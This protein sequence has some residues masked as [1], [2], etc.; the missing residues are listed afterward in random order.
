M[1]NTILKVL[2]SNGND[3]TTPYSQAAENNKKPISVVLDNY[4]DK[5]NKVLEIGSGTGQHIEYFSKLFSK[6]IWQ[7]TDIA[8]TFMAQDLETKASNNVLSYFQLNVSNKAHWPESKF[9]AVYTANTCH[10]MAW[11]EVLSMFELLNYILL[12]G[13]FFI[14]YGPFKFGGKFTTESNHNFDLF[15]KK[16]SSEMGLRSFEA[17]ETAANNNALKFIEKYDM[18]ANN[19]ILVFQK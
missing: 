19:H 5:G 16:Q 2:S 9:N 13:G 7:P 18:P 15:L 3:M 6:V 12:A 8:E 1:N 4:L 17:I 11:T 14:C 10:I